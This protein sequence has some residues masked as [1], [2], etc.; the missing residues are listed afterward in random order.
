[1]STRLRKGVALT[2]KMPK[3]HKVGASGG[4]VT[5]YTIAK[6]VNVSQSTVSLVLSGKAGKRVAPATQALI[7]KTARD[8]GY[9][10]NEIARVL[11]T[12]S[13]HLL[14]LAV[15]NV[16]QPFFS[17]VLAAAELEAR[18]NGY[19]VILL[20]TTTDPEWPD[21]LCSMIASRQIAG[22]IVYAADDAS[23]PR[24][25]AIRENAIFIEA[26]DA[27][28]SCVDLDILDGIQ[29]VVG[30]LATLGHRQ[31]G[32]FAADYDKAAYH[33][34]YDAFCAIAEAQGL[35]HFA[36][37]RAKAIFALEAATEAAAALLKTQ[38]FTALVCDDDLLAAGVYRAARRLGMR[39][40]EDLSVVGFDD[41]ELARALAPELTTVAIP[42][43]KIG[44]IAVRLLV[45]HIQNENAE[46]NPPHLIKLSLVIRGST[47][48]PPGQSG[49]QGQ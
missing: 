44:Q 39:I 22:C 29:Q 18:E 4:R 26:E 7:I 6:A 34:R 25:A 17:Q 15:P 30:H 43:D 32:Y 24:L 40:P 12:G 35:V 31:I 3:N 45:D 49:Q 28:R 47:A 20:G 33:R 42:A 19:S 14:A 13:T 27:G 41:I 46:P 48:A 23:E 37:W 1:M 9:Q 11:R 16:E 36:E 21:R 2:T 38:R 8:L 5:S 10:R